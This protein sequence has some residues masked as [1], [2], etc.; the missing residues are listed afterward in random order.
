[1]SVIALPAQ[2]FTT[3]FSF[4]LTDGANPFYGALVQSTNGDL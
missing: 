3:L 4:D 1:M 2:T